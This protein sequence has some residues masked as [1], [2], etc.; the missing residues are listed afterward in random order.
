MATDAR[1]INFYFSISLL[2]CE[3]N[4]EEQT[5]NITKKK[6]YCFYVVDEVDL[7]SG[8]KEWCLYACHEKDAITFYNYV[9]AKWFRFIFQYNI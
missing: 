2:Y 5:E 6:S 1:F 8:L 4:G 7:F 9:N 3:N